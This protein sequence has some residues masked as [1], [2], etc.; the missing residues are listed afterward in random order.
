M[1]K[2]Y[3]RWMGAFGHGN[4]DLRTVLEFEINRRDTAA[5]EEVT[6][7]D[8]KLNACIPQ[9]KRLRIGLMVDRHK[10]YRRFQHDCYSVYTDN[11]RLKAGRDGKSKYPRGAWDRRHTEAWLNAED[12]SY[13]AGFVIYGNLERLGGKAR[14]VIRVLSSRYNL[15]VYELSEKGKLTNRGV[16][17]EKGLLPSKKGGEQ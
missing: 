14:N 3:V 6:A 8:G 9:N 16:I 13:V 1:A 4:C 5:C 12:G 15:P 17:P 10:I 7:F 11:G 2:L